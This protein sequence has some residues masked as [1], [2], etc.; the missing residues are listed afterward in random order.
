MANKDFKVKNGIDIQSP[1]S[2]S[3]GGTG[4]TSANNSLNAMLPIQTGHSGRFLSTNG[5]DTHWAITPGYIQIGSLTSYITSRAKINF[6]GVELTDDAGNNATNVTINLAATG[7]DG[8][9]VDSVSLYDG[10]EPSTNSFM[11]VIEG[12]TP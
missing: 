5:T 11:Y 12:G 10:G 7:L 9:R 2:V 3:M 6:Y 8:G 4:Q 1:L